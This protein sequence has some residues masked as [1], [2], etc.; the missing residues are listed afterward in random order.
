M[1]SKRQQIVDAVAARL[2]QIAVGK[3]WTLQDGASRTCT[4]AVKGVHPWRKIPFSSAMLPAIGFW[5]TESTPGEAT[6]D[7]GC[8]LLQISVV[9]FVSGDAS[10]DSAR[11]LNSD[12]M[13]AIGSDTTFGGLAELSIF[14]RVPLDMEQAGDVVSAGEILITVTYRTNN[15]WMT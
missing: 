3:V 6:L 9:G 1:S 11:E 13:A 15:R 12:I 5:D 14:N 7:G 4:T 2:G 8:H 10:T